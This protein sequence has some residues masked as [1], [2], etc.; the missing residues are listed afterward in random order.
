MPDIMHATD[1]HK[2]AEDTRTISRRRLLRALVASGLAVAGSSLPS[3]WFGPEVEV[4]V[5][6]AHAQISPEPP[7]YSVLR[8]TGE[9][10]WDEVVG[11][12]GGC[13]IT[14]ADAGVEMR[15]SIVLEAAT[16]PLDGQTIV[17]QTGLTDASGL[18]DPSFINLISVFNQPP[19]LPT[20]VLHVTWSF[21]DPSVGAGTCLR[22]LVVDAEVPQ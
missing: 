17:D 22:T 8:C 11:F 16:H 19:Y 21:V 18:Y 1:D 4:G 5:L 20:Y 2:P 3:Q 10:L 9:V 12:T 14:P 15:L 7:P 6:P 13:W